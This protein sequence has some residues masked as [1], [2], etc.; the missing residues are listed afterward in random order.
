MDIFNIH[1]NQRKS[2]RA[3]ATTKAEPPMNTSGGTGFEAEA[4]RLVCWNSVWASCRAICTACRT[5]SAE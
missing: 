5:V 3:S 2:G 4:E 1:T